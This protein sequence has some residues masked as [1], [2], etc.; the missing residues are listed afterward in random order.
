V[1]V[2]PPLSSPRR[3]DA[4]LGSSW[5]WTWLRC[6]VDLYIKTA[7]LREMQDAM[8]SQTKEKGLKKDSFELTPGL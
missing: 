2:F 5:F 6:Y 8:F 4:R 7:L 1:P 3:W